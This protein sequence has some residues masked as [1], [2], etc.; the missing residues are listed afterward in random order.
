LRH[1]AGHDHLGAEAQAREEH[2]HLRRVVFCASSRI[3]KASLS[4]RPRM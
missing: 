2:L 1:V 3:T 4:V